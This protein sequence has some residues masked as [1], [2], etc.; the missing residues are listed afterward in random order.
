MRRGGIDEGE[1]TKRFSEVIALCELLLRPDLIIVSGGITARWSEMA[2]FVESRVQLV[3]AHF[4]DDAGII[5]ASI[6]ARSSGPG[7]P[8]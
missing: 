2:D 4:Q 7:K 1:W 8:Q 5:G 3:P 6:V